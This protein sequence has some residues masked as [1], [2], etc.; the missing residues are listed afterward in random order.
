MK[1]NERYEMGWDQLKALDALAAEGVLQSL[2]D[3]APDM[4]RFIVEFGYGDIYSRPGLDIK[5]RQIATIA[6]LTAMG[7]A[8]PQLMFH[9]NAALNVGCAPEEIIEVM[10]VTTIFSGFPAGLNGISAARKVF[11]TRDI[12]VRHDKSPALKQENRRERGLKAVAA[13][14]QGSGRNVIES[15]ADIAPDMGE[16]IIDFS[17]GDIIARNGLDLK[18]KEIAIIAACVARGTMRPQLTVHIRAALN[19]GC[20]Q[21]EIV[22][23]IIQ[24]AVYS[25]FPSALNGLFAAREVFETN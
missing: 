16:F 10:Y 8:E 13:T 4:G 25:G 17:Y 9:I 18:L 22:E 2:N 5:S 11:E 21:N 7:N 15:L 6:A 23:V 19:V 3:I 12:T 1:E 20:T 14:S 24:M